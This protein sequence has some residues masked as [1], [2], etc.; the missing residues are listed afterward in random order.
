MDIGGLFGEIPSESSSPHTNNEDPY[1]AKDR[2]ERSLRP[3]SCRIS[4]IQSLTDSIASILKDENARQTLR[5]VEYC[6]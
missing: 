5:F 2:F 1:I 4:A 6:A 3:I